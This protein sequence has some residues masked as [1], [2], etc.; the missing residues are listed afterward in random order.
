MGRPLDS[1]HSHRDT[2]ADMNSDA[3]IVGC[4]VD[5]IASRVRPLTLNQRVYYY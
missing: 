2:I 1:L 4:L 3:I 5:R